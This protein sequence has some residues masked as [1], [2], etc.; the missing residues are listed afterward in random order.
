[1]TNLAMKLCFAVH[2]EQSD[3]S[4]LPY[5]F[6]PFHLAEQMTDEDSTVVALLHD[7]LEDS[8]LTLQELRDMGFGERVIE[9][10]ALLTHDPAVPYMDYVAQLKPNALAKAVKLAD[11][12]HN[13]DM[14]R[15]EQI[16]PRDVARAEKYRKAMAYLEDEER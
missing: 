4:G 6:H 8:A 13:S 9:A 15:F 7:V 10:I 3:K 11:L 2:K 12:R 5:V 1:M 14:T 16:T